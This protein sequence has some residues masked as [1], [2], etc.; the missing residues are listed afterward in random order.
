MLKLSVSSK[1]PRERY[2]FDVAP[3]ELSLIFL[4]RSYK[5]VAPTEL[6]T[7]RRSAT[8][9]YWEQTIRSRRSRR[10]RR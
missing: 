5:Y 1:H 8:F 6:P 2:T 9:C 3:T 10:S 7:S 4:A